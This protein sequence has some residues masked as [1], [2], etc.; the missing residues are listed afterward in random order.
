[1]N[2]NL[3][4]LISY[5]I[6][7]FTGL[8]TLFFTAFSVSYALSSISMFLFLP[9]F[10]LD[11]KINLKRKLQKIINNK[12]VIFCVLFF[13]VQCIGYFYS[14]DKTLAINKI[15]IMLPILFLPAILFS[16]QMPSKAFK[17]VI[18]VSK[19]FILLTFLFYLLLHVFVYER[20]INTFVHFT[21][22]AKLGISQFYLTFIILVP[23][24]TAIKDV[25]HK[26][27]IILN[28]IVALFSFFILLLLG[29]KTV[30]FFILS[31]IIICVFMLIN[32]KK[33]KSAILLSLFMLVGALMIWQTSIVKNRMAVFVKTIDFDFETIVT[34]NKF[35]VTKNTLEHR[36]LINYLA[37]KEII[38]AFPFGVGT[39]DFQKVLDEQYKTIN[40]K[41]G[42]MANYNNHNQ[43]LAE[44]LK[45]GVLGGGLF[46]IL[47]IL[48]LSK[49]N[50][51]QFQYPIFLLF[52][53]VGCFLESYLDRQHG[54][55]IF[56]FLIPF[57][58][59]QDEHHKK[60]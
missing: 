50:K 13:L 25:F 8:C 23:L 1:M 14:E 34:K 6:Q 10:F 48:Y 45:T 2:I 41:A 18:N 57:F 21:I 38:N 33:Y 26:K 28:S 12:I 46:I 47:L 32:R 24:L 43:Y 37:G 9:F 44:F 51:Q 36:I 22:E 58:Y 3:E 31:L 56:A 20:T 55:A 19:Y 15:L 29:N 52:F 16:E 54:V 35:T 53:I 39:G 40:F 5:R 42:L 60:A 59:L 11:T 49:I 4:K 30:L 7:I 27:K 17:E